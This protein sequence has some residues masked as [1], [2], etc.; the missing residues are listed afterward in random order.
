MP[1]SLLFCVFSLEI[2]MFIHITG[3]PM[4]QQKETGENPTWGCLTSEEDEI[5]QVQISAEI[6]LWYL[7]QMPIWGS[8]EIYRFCTCFWN[9]FPQPS[10]QEETARQELPATGWL[11]DWHCGNLESYS[12]GVSSEQCAAVGGLVEKLGDVPLRLIIVGHNPS[13]HAWKSG[14]YYSNPSNRY[15]E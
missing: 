13:E 10:D 8:T 6:P 5:W 7:E 3:L 11:G 1:R 4:Q 9:Q 2:L 15:R 14:H 12:L